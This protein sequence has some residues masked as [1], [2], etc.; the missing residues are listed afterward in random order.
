MPLRAP[1]WRRSVRA[2]SLAARAVALGRPLLVVDARLELLR[3]LDAAAP[4]VVAFAAV[5][6]THRLKSLAL[7]PKDFFKLAQV[8]AGTRVVVDRR[9]HLVAGRHEARFRSDLLLLLMRRFITVL[10]LL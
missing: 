6:A 4:H 7:A 8:L 10:R 1:E 3:V 9:R 5:G 2:D